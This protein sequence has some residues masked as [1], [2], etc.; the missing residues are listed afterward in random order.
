MEDIVNMIGN[1]GFP[2]FLVVYLFTRFEKLITEVIRSIEE[3]EDFIKN[4]TVQGKK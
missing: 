2:I 1:F 3:L 4:N